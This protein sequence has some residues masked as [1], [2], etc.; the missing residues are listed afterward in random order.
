M[1]L[2]ARLRVRPLSDAE[3]VHLGPGSVLTQA[4]GGS[5][6]SVRLSETIIEEHGRPSVLLAIIKHH[7]AHGRLTDVNV[8]LSREE[9]V[10][11]A[12]RLLEHAAGAAW[13]GSVVN[14]SCS[15][16]CSSSATWSTSPRRSPSAISSAGGGARLDASESGAAWARSGR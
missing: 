7:F 8:E 4:E 10:E 11:L 5:T 6:V 14:R 15:S 2:T 13:H 1:V 16:C 9:A 12:A 3:G